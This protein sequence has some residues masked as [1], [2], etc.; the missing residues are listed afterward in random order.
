MYKFVFYNIDN[1]NPTSVPPGRTHAFA[2]DIEFRGDWIP[3]L[4]WAARAAD[5]LPE[6]HY[7]LIATRSESTT[8][9]GVW[10]ITA[11]K[12]IEIVGGIH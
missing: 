5:E 8:V 9:Q 1:V 4:D 2:P 7:V 11:K 12:S 6:G 3:G 10:S